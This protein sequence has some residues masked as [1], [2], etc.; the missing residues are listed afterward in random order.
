MK[1]H[2]F[3]ETITLSVLTT[4]TAYG[5]PLEMNFQSGWSARQTQNVEV[6]IPWTSS[7]AEKSGGDMIMHIFY[8]NGI[9]EQNS[10]PDAIKSGML[11]AG[12]WSLQ[13]HKKMPYTYLAGLP[14]L[15]KNQDHAYRVSQ[16]MMEEVPELK[17]EID[18]VGVLVG[19]TVTPPYM[20]ASR[21]FPVKSPADI[22]GRRVLCVVPTLAEYVEAWGGIPVMVSPG[23]IY[24]GLQ[25]GMGEMILCGVSCIKGFRAHEVC[26]YSTDLGMAS[27]NI[28]PFSINKDLFEKDMT[29][30]QR[31]LTR[32]L[33]KNLGKDLMDSYRGELER[34][35]KEFE[36]AGCKV[37]RLSEDETGAFVE[38]ARANIL[39]AY[40]RKA[41]DAGIDEPEKIVKRYQ[42]IAA[43]ID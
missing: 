38:E 18:S 12:L 1:L 24:I 35:Y 33:S 41:K 26:R 27:F 16:K 9:V 2:H 30:K 31:E 22:K 15:A 10:V 7:F 4:A 28:I 8:T 19:S 3:I 20:M 5:A 36:S 6:V 29:E 23:D 34:I 25:R 13:D 42:E 39:P 32:E 11:D 21:D 40:V 37:I 14:Y 43:G 17:A